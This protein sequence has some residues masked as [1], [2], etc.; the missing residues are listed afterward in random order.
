MTDRYNSTDKKVPENA[1]WALQFY[2]GMTLAFED[3]SSEGVSLNVSVLD[4][5]PMSAPQAIWR[6]P[7]RM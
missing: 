2:N 5:R 4:S 6:V 7:T 1:T 3:L